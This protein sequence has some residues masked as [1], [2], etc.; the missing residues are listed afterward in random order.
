MKAVIILFLIGLQ[1][2]IIYFLP[3][4]KINLENNLDRTLDNDSELKFN[5]QKIDSLLWMG[6]K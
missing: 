1:V 5:D 4:D 3:S 2:V 6:T